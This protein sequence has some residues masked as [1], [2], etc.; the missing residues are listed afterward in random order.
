MTSG[1]QPFGGLACARVRVLIEAY[2]DGDLASTDPAL[3]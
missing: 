3:A 2:V 1:A